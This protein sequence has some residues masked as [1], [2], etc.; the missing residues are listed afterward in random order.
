[1]SRIEKL[2]RTI[3]IAIGFGM[4]TYLI[5]SG[6][7]ILEQDSNTSSEVHSNTVK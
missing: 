4:A 6:M 5:M 1:M 7:A 2:K 3:L